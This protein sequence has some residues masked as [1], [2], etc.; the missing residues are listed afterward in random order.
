MQIDYWT[1]EEIKAYREDPNLLFSKVNELRYQVLSQLL[2]QLRDK[3]V[4]SL[5]SADRK[6]QDR[7]AAH[8]SEQGVMKIG[9]G[10]QAY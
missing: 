2:R 5:H 8:E 6:M 3:I 9:S 7:E 4:S 1:R 10:K